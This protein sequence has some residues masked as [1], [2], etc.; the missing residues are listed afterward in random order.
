MKRINVRLS[1]LLSLLLM[2]TP[3]SL[4][5]PWIGTNDESLHQDLRTLVE[6]QVIDAVAISYP[7]PWRGIDSQLRSLD[8]HALPE[9]AKRAARRLQHYLKY[10]Q[11]DVLRQITSARVAS[12]P[13]R[14]DSVHGSYG[15]EVQLS[16]Q[17][18]VV[19]GRWSAKLS[20][21]MIDDENT[22]L[23]NSY[24]AMHLGEWIVKAGAT[25]QFWGPANDSSLIL[26][27]N[28]RPI[29]TV[30]LFK[31]S[32]VASESPWL[33]WL[34]AWY[35]SAE[36]G[37]FQDVREIEGAKLWRARFTAAPFKGLTFGM[38]WVAMWG[39]AGQPN[40]IGDLVD[41]LTFQTQ[42][43]DELETCD[44]ELNTTTGNHIAGF[45]L[46]YSFKL[47][48]QPITLY[49]QRIG[50]DAKDYK[51][52][53]N[54]NLL[55]I[56]TYVGS[57]KLYLEN[58]DTNIACVGDGNTATNCYYEHSIYQS[59]Y[60]HYNR[61][62]GSTYDSDAKQTTLGIQWRGMQGRSA[63][64]KMSQIELN[65]DKGRP[66][67][68]LTDSASEELKLVSGYYQQPYGNFLVRIGAEY[69]DRDLGEKHATDTS[70]F[71]DLRYVWY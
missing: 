54:A 14:F 42:C 3:M 13:V 17:A 53:D 38:S 55:G 6:F 63:M 68:V 61:A 60:R 57:F 15:Q 32:A 12:D 4:A 18:E 8:T 45:D 56:S 9:P 46:A 71:L 51:V 67:P 62:V 1:S 25:D 39:G 52:T 36:I 27:T 48:E 26:S 24:V 41:V 43:I 19:T 40:S 59:G 11:Q 69:Q 20:A 44:K 37:K 34:G 35:A 21:N 70:V 29:P 30:G 47:L 64:L 65:S 33:S 2:A 7:V 5:S 22:N 66:S 23:D 49:G 58:S 31:S 28:A 50:E 10:R 16:H